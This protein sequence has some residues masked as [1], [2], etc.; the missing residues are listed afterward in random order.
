M[1]FGRNLAAANR[2]LQRR[3]S[4][5]SLTNNLSDRL[6]KLESRLSAMETS[7]PEPTSAI[8]GPM[9]EAVPEAPVETG[10]LG[11]TGGSTVGPSNVSETAGAATVAA[12]GM[13]SNFSPQAQ[14]VAADVYGQNFG[15]ANAFNT[16]LGPSKKKM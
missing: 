2:L 12:A 6:D 1:M 16:A 11:P 5:R 9:A 15:M 7:A 14:Q 3:G 13:F 10:D 8:G 4:T